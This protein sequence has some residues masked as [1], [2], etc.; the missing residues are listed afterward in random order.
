MQEKPPTSLCEMTFLSERVPPKSLLTSD[1]RHDGCGHVCTVTTTWDWETRWTPSCADNNGYLGLTQHNTSVKCAS[2]TVCSKARDVDMITCEGDPRHVNL[3]LRD[4]DW[5]QRKKQGKTVLCVGTNPRSWPPAN[6]QKLQHP[7][8]EKLFHCSGS[9]TRSVHKQS[10]QQS[11]GATD[12]Q[13]GPHGEKAPQL[14]PH[15]RKIVASTIVRLSDPGSVHCD[16]YA[17]T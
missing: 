14:L 6:G 2:R 7:M 11:D 8:H 12:D 10:N 15:R 4:C 9:A 5:K 3:L 13:N 17:H 16:A 1:P